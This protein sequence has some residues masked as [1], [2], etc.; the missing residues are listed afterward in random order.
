MILRIDGEPGAHRVFRYVSYG[1]PS[2][3]AVGHQRSDRN[4]VLPVGLHRVRRRLTRLA[5]IEEIGE[6][7]RERIDFRRCGI[8]VTMDRRPC[9]D[10]TGGHTSRVTDKRWIITLIHHLCDRTTVHSWGSD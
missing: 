7:L 8:R 5:V 10:G 3:V 4:E 1:E 6:P 2:G 9:G